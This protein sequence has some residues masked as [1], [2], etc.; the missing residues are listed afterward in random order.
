MEKQQR[1]ECVKLKLPLNNLEQRAKTDGR[2]RIPLFRKLTAID[3]M[4][5]R[6]SMLKLEYAYLRA[7]FLDLLTII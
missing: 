5:P 3:R 1:I 6:N 2:R 7:S 4:L